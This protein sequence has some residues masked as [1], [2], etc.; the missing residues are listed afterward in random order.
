M[1]RPSSRFSFVARRLAWGV[2]VM[3]LVLTVTWLIL[4]SLPETRRVFFTKVEMGIGATYES[5]PG[6]VTLY[7]DWMRRFL[8]FQW[9][10]S[11]YYEQSVVSLYLT[12]LPVTLA[13]VVPAVLVSVFVGSGLS[14]YAAIRRNGLLDRALSLLSYV[15]LSLP[16]FLLSVITL[17]YMS[18]HLGMIRIYD[19]SLPLWAKENLFGFAFP[20]AIVALNF[21]ALQVRHA[22]S[23][24]TEHL[25][26]KYV[27]TAR[28][29]GAGQL[30]TAIHVFR[31]VW[32]SLGA[33]VLG[34][35][36]GLL[37]LSTVVV[38]KVLLIPGI[39]VAVFNGFAA[40]D[41]MLSFTAVFGMVLVGVLGTLI[42]DFARV[43][44]DPR[45]ES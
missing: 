13:Y 26:N 22:Q 38:E 15:G 19:P 41:P 7:V 37:F 33:L 5:S 35:L 29:K 30:R 42:Q 28:A 14:T 21:L 24:T 10:Q 27:K 23:E 2:A 40:G 17:T 44:F 39:A 32:P 9:G 18:T 11:L 8:T 31:N 36:I 3:W 43:L 34:E 12:R 6:L 4:V 45:V 20:A 25:G 16:A 1:V